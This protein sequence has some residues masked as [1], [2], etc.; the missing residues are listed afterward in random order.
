MPP[1]QVE[2]FGKETPPGRPGQ[3]AVVAPVYVLLASDDASYISGARIAFASGEVTVAVGGVLAPG[4]PN[5]WPASPSGRRMP[6]GR[7]VE[8]TLRPSGPVRD[9]SDDCPM[10][11]DVDLRWLSWICVR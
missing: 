2:K 9:R 6:D 7:G 10:S 11:G 4:R 1:E 3:P 5:V 8:C